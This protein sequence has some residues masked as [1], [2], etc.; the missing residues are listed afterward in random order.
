MPEIATPIATPPAHSA[1]RA[2]MSRFTSTNA[3]AEERTATITE[4]ATTGTL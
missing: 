2:V 4:S 1:R 3:T